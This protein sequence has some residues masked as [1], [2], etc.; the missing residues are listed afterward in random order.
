VDFD[1]QQVIR[2]IGADNKARPV[3]SIANSDAVGDWPGE[4]QVAQ[5]DVAL[6]GPHLWP[7]LQE[8]IRAYQEGQDAKINGLSLDVEGLVRLGLENGFLVPL[9]ITL[10]DRADG[11]SKPGGL[12]DRGEVALQV[13]PETTDALPQP[14]DLLG[15]A[16][17]F[18]NEGIGPVFGMPQELHGVVEVAPIREAAAAVRLVGD[19]ARGVLPGV[20]VHGSLLSRPTIAGFDLVSVF[21]DFLQGHIMYLRPEFRG[22]GLVPAYFDA[23]LALCRR[24]GLRGMFFLSTLPRWRNAAYRFRIGGSIEQFNGP[25]VTLYWRLA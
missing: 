13:G 5:T 19:G 24:Q 7:L 17:D 11:G 4:L 2:A 3:S 25:D 16:Q 15:Q 22:R 10:H 9:W 6:P 18:G 14:L 1:L 21:E 23:A 8:G 20:A 12:G